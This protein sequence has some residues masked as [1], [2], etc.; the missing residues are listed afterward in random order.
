MRSKRGHLL[1]TQLK[2]SGIK[3][4]LSFPSLVK[5]IVSPL[6]KYPA[7]VIIVIIENI[8]ERDDYV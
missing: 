8:S 4:V 7:L 2:Y 5:T 1:E 3:I 6:E